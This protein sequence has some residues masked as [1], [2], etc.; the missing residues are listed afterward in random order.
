MKHHLAVYTG[1]FDPITLGHL[2]VLERSRGMFSEIVLAIGHNPSKPALF[3]FEE[4]LDLARA[5]SV[6]LALAAP[7]LTTCTLRVT[8]VL[9][10]ISPGK[11]RLTVPEPSAL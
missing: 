5:R 2:D 11:A 6:K 10:T 1:S 3:S 4:R 7:W 8:E 9:P